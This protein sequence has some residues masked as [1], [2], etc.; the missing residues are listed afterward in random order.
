MLDS[1]HAACLGLL[2]R[3]VDRMKLGASI[4]GGV[5]FFI[6]LSCSSLADANVI[7]NDTWWVDS[8]GSNVLASMGGHITLVGD[9]YYWVGNDPQR[10]LNGED[11]HLYSSKTLGSGSWKHEG[12]MVDF[13][14]GTGASN[15]S[16]L[17]S[18]ATGNYVI[19]AK[20]GLQ[21]YESASITGPYTHVNTVNKFQIDNRGGNY[22]IGG[23]GTFQDGTNAYVITSRRWL[24][25][26][27]KSETEGANHRYTGIYKLTPDFLD[28]AEEVCWLRNDSR[29]AMW[30]FKKDDTYYMTG[31]HTAGWT[32]SAC[33]Y[34]TSTNLEDWSAEQEIGMDPERPG[35][36]QAQK[37][38]RS[39]G[40]QHR[41]IIQLGNGQWMYGG[42]RYPYDEP[43]SH[44]F[45]KGL[46]IFCPVVWDNGH[47]TV[48]WEPV[49]TAIAPIEAGPEV[50]AVG[51]HSPADSG[52]G[53]AVQDATPD[54]VFPGLSGLLGGGVDPS[55]MNVGG[56]REWSGAADS[57]DGTYGSVS[58]PDPQPSQSGM[59]LLRSRRNQD[60]FLDVAVTNGTGAP[61][62]L[63]S[64]HFDFQLNSTNAGLDSLAVEHLDVVSDLTDGPVSLFATN[65]LA[66]GPWVDVDLDLTTL[67]A[68]T[69]LLDGETAAFRISIPDN[70]GY[71]FM[72]IDNVAISILSTA[73]TY[74]T[75]M[76]GYG[77]TGSNALASADLE[78][79][80]MNNLLE[81]ALGGNPTTN[82]AAFLL[83]KGGIISEL[84]TNWLEY[85]YRRRSDYA[86][87]GLTYTVEA[88]TNLVTDIWTTNGVV[89]AGTGP[90]DADFDTVTNRVSTGTDDR[91][92]MRLKLQT[93]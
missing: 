66:I 86:A 65:G 63:S 81:Y 74:D 36:T 70:D 26:T 84:G 39:H 83:P 25:S 37:I 19:V 10:S 16:L 59:V 73:D 55:K 7:S 62:T 13:A 87:R 54:H 89:D 50:L 56:G 46:Y 17:Y 6:G 8:N 2:K 75:Y 40:S 5:L 91:Q 4:A 35:G 14:P 32:A 68:D 15:C 38:M 33:Y 43:E 76:T 77:L 51:W 85:V 34:R 58:I 31:S 80:G 24:P 72:R 82:D 28:V 90:I 21:F 1:I 45:E 57:S 23:M 67:L 47:P 9:T 88:T 79:D 41:F 18:H 29:E 12:K 52:A 3:K 93:E 60:R 69:I 30:L 71:D 44:P 42:D 11:I 78:P 61:V 27:P 48:K 53:T 92:F 22:K 49:W 20:S 64:L